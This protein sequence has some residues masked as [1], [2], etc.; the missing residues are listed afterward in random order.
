MT[1]EHESATGDA[2][3]TTNADARGRRSLLGALG[4]TVV[5]SAGLAAAADRAS[6]ASRTR[7]YVKELLH[8]PA[9]V[10]FNT[11]SDRIRSSNLNE[12]ADRIHDGGRNGAT[13]RLSGGR[14]VF[15][16]PPGVELTELTVSGRGVV[17]V[18]VVRDGV[19]PSYYRPL[20]VSAGGGGR[21][22]YDLQFDRPGVGSLYGVETDDVWRGRRAYGRVRG[23]ETD[24]GEARG[25]IELAKFYPRGGEIRVRRR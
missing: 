11:N 2:S 22:T 6:A 18:N 10:W 1:P 20:R 13:A 14:D 17:H 25:E 23:T 4:A 5:G 9:T 16:I 19:G 24:T 7:I 21:M 12:G 15:R 3:A 8:R